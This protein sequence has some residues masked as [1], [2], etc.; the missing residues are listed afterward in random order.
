M[1]K[2]TITTEDVLRAARS[3]IGQ[4]WIQGELGLKGKGVC[5]LGGISSALEFLHTNNG[6]SYPQEYKPKN[7]REAT[8]QNK[9]LKAMEVLYEA[10]PAKVRESYETSIHYTT[11]NY[12]TK[13]KAK[14]NKHADAIVEYNDTSGR[15]KRTVT[16]W[17]DRAIEMAAK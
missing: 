4:F 15:H 12:N 9:A 6:M 11:S 13:K 17:F 7:K 5:A 3:E 16:K 8:L 1:S 14:A 2:T 10:L